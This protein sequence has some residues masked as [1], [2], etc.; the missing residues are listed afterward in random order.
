MDYYAVCIRS[1]TTEQLTDKHGLITLTY[2]MER[3]NCFV[4]RTDCFVEQSD[5]YV[6]RS[7]LEQSDHGTK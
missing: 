4:E 1:H 2:D 7:D 3:S 6:E 5:Y